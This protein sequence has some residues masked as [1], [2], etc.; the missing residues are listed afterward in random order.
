MILHYNGI[1]NQRANVIIN[2]I[3]AN[4]LKGIDQVQRKKQEQNYNKR[5]KRWKFFITCWCKQLRKCE[6]LSSREAA[7]VKVKSL[8]LFLFERSG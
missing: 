2:C 4:K 5:K 7:G 3:T 8:L 1:T 6:Y